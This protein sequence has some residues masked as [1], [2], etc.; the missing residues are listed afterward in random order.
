[1]YKI[2]VYDYKTVNGTAP[3]YFE[4]LVPYQLTKCLRSESESLITVTQMQAVIYGNRC[5][6]KAATTLWN[7]L[8]L[9]I[10]KGKT[11]ANFCLFRI[12]TLCKSV[13][14]CRKYNIVTN[15]PQ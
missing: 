5:F 14:L 13:I 6:D 8:L 1:M 4:E 9:A 7:N 3:R 15:P 2:L 12:K 11:L 10:R